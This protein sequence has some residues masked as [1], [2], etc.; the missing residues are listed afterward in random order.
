[1]NDLL[2]PLSAAAVL[3]LQYFLS[4]RHNIYFGAIIP[5]LVIGGLTWML[6]T[7]LVKSPLA[8]ILIL[9]VLLLFLLEQWSRGRKAL[10]TNTQEELDKMEKH[11]IS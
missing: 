2:F 8:Y 7:D 10:R 3:G 4:S 5:I 11:D 1:M 9:V 6:F